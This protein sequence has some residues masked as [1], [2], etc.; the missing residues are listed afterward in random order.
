MAPSEAPS[1]APS[2]ALPPP[3]RLDAKAPSKAPS[4]VEANTKTTETRP[5]SSLVSLVPITIV[6]A[7]ATDPKTFKTKTSSSPTSPLDL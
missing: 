7:A 6:P 2:K 1:E 3:P 5:S 4:K